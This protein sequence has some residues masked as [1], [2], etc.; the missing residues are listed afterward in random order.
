MG[1]LLVALSLGIPVGVIAA[2]RRNTGYDYTLMAIA[3]VGI[4]LPTFVIGPMLSIFVGIKLNLLPALGWWNPGIDW[5]LPAVALG[6]FYGAY[7]ARLTRAGMLETLS[8]DYIRTAR[9]KGLSEERVVLFHALKGGLVPVVSYLGPAVAGLIGGSLV[10]ETIFQLPGLGRHIINAAG[11]RDYPLIDG[12]VLTYGILIVTM[13]FISDILLVI[14]NPRQ[15]GLSQ[16]AN[17]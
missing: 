2:A 15:R 8:Q 10:M 11:N 17:A 1:G 16:S 14:L 7:I 4:C 5:I 12:T 6:I 13:N 9:A 3:M